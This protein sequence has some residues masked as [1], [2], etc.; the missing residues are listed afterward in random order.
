MFKPS[1]IFQR[2]KPRRPGKK[3]IQKSI[4]ILEK[5]GLFDEAYY[6]SEYPDVE[7]ANVKA[8]RHFLLY[9]GFEGRNPNPYFDSTLYLS[10]FPRL[11]KKRINPLL[12][13]IESRKKNVTAY[14][15]INI[16]R[17]SGLFD[18]DFYL[19]N[20]PGLKNYPIDPIEHFY[21]F[22]AYTG[23]DPNPNFN[24]SVYLTHHR[25]VKKSGINPLYH[26]IVEGSQ[27][28]NAINSSYTNL[29][30]AITPAI[31]KDIAC[32]TESELFDAEYYAAANLKNIPEKIDPILHFCVYGWKEGRN[33]NREFDTNFYL[34]EYP[35]V[36]DVGINPFVHW[37]KKGRSEGRLTN[38]IRIYPPTKPRVNSPSLIFVSHEAT[39]T[40]APAVLLTLMRWLKENTQINFSIVVGRSGPWNYKFEEMAPTFFIDLECENRETKLR[41]F[42]G[43]HVKAVYLNTIVAGE[44]VKHFH[45]LNAEFVTHIH[46]MENVFK[47]FEIHVDVIKNICT[48]YI[49][50]SEGSVE[51]ISKRV[52]SGSA[53]I[54]LLR[55]F[56]EPKRKPGKPIP[57]PSEKKAI[58]GCG[59]TEL[60]KGFD[61]F[62]QV[63]S[64]LKADGRN[65]F[66][67]YWI[68]S[69][70]QTDLN[71]DEVIE[72]SNV[73]DV[74]S[75]LGPK[76]YPR[77]YFEWG[78]IFLLTSRED[79]HPLVCLEAAECGMPIVCFD[80]QAGSI[81][82][83]V[84]EDAGKVTPYLDI[85]RMT[86]AVTHYLDDDTA[87]V[88]AGQAGRKK[89]L[90]KYYVNN[91]APQI[92]SFLPSSVF[93]SFDTGDEIENLKV[94]IDKY[95]AI[96]FDIF[97]TLVVRKVTDPNIAFDI[98]ERKLSK[99]EPV[100]IPFHQER[101]STA[102]RVLGSY[103]GKRD[104]VSLTEIYQQMPFH[105]D[106]SVE[107]E[108]EM[109]L[110]TAHPTGIQLF[111][112]AQEKNKTIFL[113]SD[114]YLDKETV[115]SILK[116]TGIEGWAGLL[117]SSDM[118]KKKDTGRLYIELV[119][120]AAKQKVSKDKILHI[121]DN[122]KGDVEYARK[123]GIA[124]ARFTPLYDRDYQLCPLTDK[125]RSEMSQT[126]RIWESFCSQAARHWLEERPHMLPEIFIRLGYELT[127]PMAMMSAIHTHDIAKLYGAE[128]IVFMARDG[129]IIK[130]AFDRLYETELKNKTIESKYLHLSRSTVI[131]A[132]L[133]H[134]LSPNDIYLLM[135]GIH[136][137]QKSV[138][139]FL[140]KANLDVTSLQV[141]KTVRNYFKSIDSIPV[142]KDLTKL[143][144]LLTELSA[145]IHSANEE[146]RHLLKQYLQDN[147]MFENTRIVFADVGWLLNIQSRIC[148]FLKQH[149]APGTIIGSYVGS[150]SRESKG[151][152]RHCLLYAGGEPKHYAMPFEKN[153]TLA[154]LLFS[155]PEAPALSLGNED[156]SV[157]IN[158]A[159][160][161]EFDDRSEF[162]IA[163]KLHYG[164]EKFIQW[165]CENYDS[166]M[167]EQPPRDFFA[168]I[169]DALLHTT[170][171][172]VRAE[173][174]NLSILLGGGHE[175][176][177]RQSLLAS[178][179]G[180]RYV[181]RSHPEYFDPII[182]EGAAY[183]KVTIVTS[184]GL[185]NGSTRYR[186][187]NLA[188]R[189]SEHGIQ[190]T[191]IHSETPPLL[192]QRHID[193]SQC[194][195]FQR[196]FQDQGNVGQFLSHVKST[197]KRC[198]MDMDD[199]V[200]PDTVSVIG[201]VKGGQ[202]PLRHAEKIA[203]LYE[204]MLVEM[205]GCF[206]STPAIQAFIEEKY[207]LPC[208]V[209]RNRVS[210]TYLHPPRI[211]P[212][213][214]SLKVIYASGTMSHREDFLVV[215]NQLYEFFS[216]HTN[217]S[218]T[219]LGATQVSAQI[220]SLPTVKNYP[221]LP[222]DEML[223]CIAEHDLMIVP[224]EDNIFNHAKSAVK[225]VECAAVN[226]PV[227]ASKV[228]E[229]E[230]HIDHMKNGLLAQTEDEWR[231]LLQWALAH[232]AE[233]K[234]MGVNACSSCSQ[235]PLSQYNDTAL[236]KFII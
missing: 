197:S 131:N 76:K 78:S 111:R 15:R 60:R 129:R 177:T 168:G 73:A 58:F 59:P 70:T 136:L 186:A 179:T 169:F 164:A 87:R 227:L 35:D 1:F 215:G 114:M 134:P 187:L 32:I 141:K 123:A 110:C 93:E 234:K 34:S 53:D 193:E 182:Y 74:V 207:N 5:S 92:L 189:L 95:N 57:K 31:R 226:V 49:A 161:N 115:T 192:A 235:Q 122:W 24:T 143:S 120:H 142:W 80:D 180:V 229:F 44:F 4:A 113:T 55:P 145:A 39:Q 126:G 2:K 133:Q 63:A 223:S 108:T 188:E 50:V 38:E 138:G 165:F 51:S 160:N 128:Q 163:Q 23:C 147:G 13:F 12:D 228:S 166:V 81:H 47:I 7:Q 102:G 107:R 224:L 203:R 178:P 33:P 8:V 75:F 176:E 25:Q 225:F 54:L 36:D 222:Y 71:A 43:D 91:A 211:V 190:A 109:A 52:P 208:Q 88:A 158:F 68:G 116:N 196:C 159:K 83:F 20:N 112:Y 124:C 148:A 216:K 230:L 220:L 10:Q 125:A 206:V 174:S 195:V 170:N 89:V 84:E 209:V 175:F 11:E 154:E 139:Y 236:T 172:N 130:K 61:L 144:E 41:T 46:E 21:F 85:D 173:L 217:A 30:S 19:D 82:T 202:W 86:E 66:H 183:R 96:S 90:D 210:R 6:L 104:D 135:D 119:R 56:I 97:D 194:V 132:T 162:V 45:F 18:S 22:G 26:C 151:I 64:Q 42:C 219:I 201:S 146:S 28:H 212:P 98:V 140:E 103:K 14:K 167:L 198:L 199:L 213:T 40:G 157:A 105:K 155:A 16:I 171:Q 27:D 67:M 99:N 117:L 152:L 9:G 127:G 185:D 37:I 106:P 137:N 232:P 150:R 205:D 72:S 77:D 100:P 221:V 156:G 191:V 231:E 79:P 218:L 29:S 62:C 94:L 118:G 48:K 153:I 3:E 65:D 69:G 233:L 181:H 17:K 149:G 204:G 121:G 101:M 200:F 184:A 214:G